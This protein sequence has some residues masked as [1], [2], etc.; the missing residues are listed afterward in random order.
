MIDV[1]VSALAAAL[2][3]HQIVSAFCNRCG[4]DYLAA[5]LVHLETIGADPEPN[6]ALV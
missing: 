3:L 5:G 1:P 2:K 6:L 4:T